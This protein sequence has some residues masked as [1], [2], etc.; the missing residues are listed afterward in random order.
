MGEEKHVSVSF[1]C[2]TPLKGT[3]F[4]AAAGTTGATVRIIAVIAR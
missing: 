2:S 3:Y 1:P 4:C